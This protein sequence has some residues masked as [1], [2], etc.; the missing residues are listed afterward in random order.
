[1]L[2]MSLSILLFSVQRIPRYALLLQDL[3]K[4]TDAA[5]PDYQAC[6]AVLC[7]RAKQLHAFRTTFFLSFSWLSLNTALAKMKDIAG[8]LNASKSDAELR[9]R[10]VELDKKL[11]G[12]PLVRN[13]FVLLLCC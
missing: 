7:A 6:G 13:R 1:M 5:H 3:F 12:W 4:E 11:S 9:A 10:F 8:H 2:G